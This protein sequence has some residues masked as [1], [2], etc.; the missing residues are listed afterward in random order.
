MTDTNIGKKVKGYTLT[1]KLGSGS[2]GDV[3][4][5]NKKTDGKNYALKMVAKTKLNNKM[6][7]TMF[8]SEVKIMS[9]MNHPNIINLFEFMESSNNY[10]LVMPVCN[11]GD[12]RKYMDK[13]G[14]SF[15]SEEEGVSLLKQIACG[16]R[17][18]HKHKVIHRDFKIENCFMNDHTILIAD[19][20]FAK[21]GEDMLKTDCGTGF[22][23]APE[24]L[25]KKPYNNLVDLW[26]VGIAFYETLFGQYPF[27]L[28]FNESELRQALRKKCGDNLP[29]P[30]KINNIS[31]ECQ[32]LLRRILTEDP[33]KRL[34]WKGFYNHPLFDKWTTGSTTKS[35]N[36]EAIVLGNAFK[37]MLEN[38]QATI[39]ENFNK[40]KFE[41]Q[42]T[43]EG[44]FFVDPASLLNDLNPEWEQIETEMV[45][46][47]TQIKL[48]HEAKQFCIFEQN[49]NRYKHE[50]H[51]CQFIT[52]TVI[53]L[54][55]VAV[56]IPKHPHITSIAIAYILLSKK[57]LMYFN[58][59]QL[60]LE[61]K[62]NLFHL[63]L[64]D[65]WTKDSCYKELSEE[66]DS[67]SESSNNFWTETV[68]P[69]VKNYHYSQYDE[70]NLI[71]LVYQKNLDLDFVKKVQEV[72]IHDIKEQILLDTQIQGDYEVYKQIVEAM[73][74]CVY[75][76]ND[77]VKIPY[78]P[79]KDFGW[80]QFTNSWKQ[81]DLKALEKI[82]G[83]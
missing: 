54:Y 3:Y 55:N 49:N 61:Q 48:I 25:D 30:L 77:F 31:P 24:I 60:S 13:R 72:K 35:P 52:T 74:C 23:K 67:R 46:D 73:A 66:I 59:I 20:G 79:D 39:D 9:E 37:K 44:S 65:E 32:D 26:A 53:K 4:T 27:G 33:T 76:A 47:Q 2:Y 64:F 12:L 41:H 83:I 36:K 21:A 22:Y 16:F 56:L 58:L 63:E 15:F 17:E 81:M 10:Y 19:L 7:R 80:K 11:N 62:K 45:D 42:N 75:A 82:V 29:M 34:T 50:A 78:N 51:R 57:A 28:C 70:A 38:A 43:F 14:L 8:M 5:V 6:L 71:P 69:T 68:L 40:A 18:L 1:K